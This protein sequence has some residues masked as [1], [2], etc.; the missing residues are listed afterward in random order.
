MK[1]VVLSRI[2]T[3]DV[4]ILKEKITALIEE[5]FDVDS[6]FKPADKVLLKPNLLML[7]SSEEAITTHPS[8][9][10]AVGLF[11]RQRG[12]EVYIGDNPAVFG[13]QHLIDEIYTGTGLK[14]IALRNGFKLL[15]SQRTVIVEDIP[16]SFWIRGFKIVNLPKLKTH[17]LIRLTLA[18]KNLYGCISGSYKS[19]LHSKYLQAECFSEH[20]LKIYRLVVPVLT[21][22]DGILAME[23]DGPAKSGRPRKLNLV[24]VGNDTLYIDYI[25][26]KLLGLPEK[27]NPLIKKAKEK[28]MLFFSQLE[29]VDNYNLQIKNFKFPSPSLL[30]ILP[31]FLTSIVKSF[32]N[33]YPSIDNH[34][35]VNCGNCYRVCPVS[36]IHIRKKKFYI[37]KKECIMCMCCSES[38]RYGAVKLKRHIFLKMITLARD[39][40]YKIKK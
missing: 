3:Y 23:G 16:F 31:D 13:H 33:Q 19:Y 5:Y 36:A 35:C 9:I 8:F 26:S 1:K 15:Y 20:L 25:V 40:F 38:C 32:I 21:I 27:D 29:V 28:K 39:V 11:L 37:R 24:A 2:D 7:A 17:G 10:E 12:C 18:T 22:M 34:L 30:D 6:I 4:E 14:D